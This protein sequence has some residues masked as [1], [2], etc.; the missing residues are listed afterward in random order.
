VMP[1]AP[2]RLCRRRRRP[3]ETAAAASG[4][5]SLRPLFSRAAPTWLERLGC[6]KGREH[7]HRGI[8]NA[9]GGGNR[10]RRWWPGQALSRL[11][12]AC[13]SSPRTA[14]MPR[15]HNRSCRRCCRGWSRAMMRASHRSIAAAIVPQP[16]RAAWVRHL[17]QTRERLRSLLDASPARPA[18]ASR[19]VCRPLRVCAPFFLFAKLREGCTL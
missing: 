13:F 18:Q 9:S 11:A 4:A 17:A 5:L 7:R 8:A 14:A 6:R 10:S 19:R 16:L 1:F 3:R 12:R 15:P 2:P